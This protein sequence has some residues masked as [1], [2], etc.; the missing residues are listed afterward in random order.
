LNKKLTFTV[1]IPT[2]DGF[3]GMACNNQNCGQYF[4]IFAEL[5]KDVMFCPYCGSEFSRDELLTTDQVEYVTEVVKEEAI[6]YVQEQ[7]QNMFKETFN[8]SSARRSGITYKPGRTQKKIVTPKYQE[9]KVDSELDCPACETKFQVYGIFGYCPGCREENL[10]V[11]DANLSIIESEIINSDNPDR[12]LRHAY[13]DLVST[14]E[15]FCTRKSSKITSEKGNFQVL[16]EAKRFF[17]QHVGADIFIGVS[18][19]KLLALRRLFQKRHIYIH[20]GGIINNK[21]VQKIPEDKLLLK[22]KAVLSIEELKL[23]T[24]GMRIILL[25]LVKAI[26]AR[27]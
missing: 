1:S 21:Y 27:G 13:G 22:K 10:L 8:T 19:E 17:K 26:E 4:K 16:F 7:L 11:Y 14:F 6:V 18:P 20:S 25:N 3:V 24:E 2:D 15:S 5:N 9:R 23:A 12:Q